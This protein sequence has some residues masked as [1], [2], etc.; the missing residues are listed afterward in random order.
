MNI[1]RILI[2]AIV[3]GTPA[4]GISAGFPWYAGVAGGAS[5][6]RPDTQ[7]SAWTL[8]SDVSIGGGVFV[9]Y[10]FSRRFSLELGY[11]YLGAAT[12]K[13][14]TGTT[15][16]GYSA[17]SG[18]GLMYVL[19]NA[20]D[21]ADR[22]GFA[23]FVRLGVSAMD[24]TATIR[25]D[26]EDNVALLA[27]IGAEWPMSNS[28]SLRGELTSFDGDAQALRASI[29]YRPSMGTQRG[30]PAA[31]VPQRPQAPQAQPQVQQPQV[32]PQAPQ[33]VP[34]QVPQPLPQIA[35]PVNTRSDC[36][37]PVAN[38]PSDAQGCALF[39]GKLR[40]V[41]FASGTASLTAVA[42]QL[43]DRLAQNLIRN[44]GV[45]IEI[46]AHTESFGNE[47]RAKEIAKQR[48]LAVA[49]HLAGR[50]VPVQRLKARAFG[51]SQ[52]L[53]PDNSTAGRR[54]NNRIELRV[55]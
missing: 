19:G 35:A 43:L 39:S 28:L 30:T 5:S 24:N 45:N 15:D 29:L 33:P 11:N 53:V 34:Q 13:N 18:S 21:I 17:L 12:L 27:G 55:F 54:Q 44:P 23:G 40:G 9:G 7:S 20:A 36:A 37:A 50:G 8:D 31:R 3:L 14:D 22:N 41:E 26:R 2:A 47:S 38:E 49:R 52:P 42:T 32:Q 48:T 51:H 46:Q 6:L 1:Y 4:V 10:D 16:I 25:L